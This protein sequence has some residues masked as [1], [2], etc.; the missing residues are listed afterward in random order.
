M[1]RKTFTRYLSYPKAKQGS[2]GKKYHLNPVFARCLRKN[3]EFSR[4]PGPAPPILTHFMIPPS[5]IFLV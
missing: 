2:D 1:S 4:V 3:R 5:R